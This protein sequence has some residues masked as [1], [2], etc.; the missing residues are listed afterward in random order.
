MRLQVLVARQSK[1]P[2]LNFRPWFGQNGRNFQEGYFRDHWRHVPK[3]NSPGQKFGNLTHFV[4]PQ[5]AITGS[6]RTMVKKTESKFSAVGPSK[7]VKFPG[8]IL[9]RPLASCSGVKFSLK[10]KNLTHFVAP[11]NVIPGS[12]RTT[13]KKTESKF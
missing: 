9:S 1:R 11:Q 10:G 7:W 12:G 4:A 5:N 3:R 8:G 6:G 2:Y 13:V